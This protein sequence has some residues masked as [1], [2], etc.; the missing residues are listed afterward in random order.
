MVSFATVVWNFCAVADI[1]GGTIV[2][3]NVLIP[4]VYT[5]AVSEVLFSV[6]KFDLM[7]VRVDIATDGTTVS[8][9]IEGSSFAA[10]VGLELLFHK[11]VVSF[12]SG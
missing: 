7:E 10:T 8:L 4:F 12:D 6:E 3:P 1:G 9:G 2:S 5:C 11:K